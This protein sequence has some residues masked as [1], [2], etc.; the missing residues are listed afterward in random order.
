MTARDYIPLKV[1]LA[2]ALLQIPAEDGSIA[3]P[4]EHAKMLTP[5]QVISLFSRDHYPIRK[6]D[7]GPD[8]HWNIMFRFIGAHRIKTAK[9]DAPEIAKGA[10]LSKDHEDFRRRALARP[11]GQKRATSPR[12]P[13]GRKLRSRGFQRR[14]APAQRGKV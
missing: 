2:A 8:T 12:W 5:D 1:R 9:K 14:P 4:H 13:K 10:R 3:I 11:C 6:I 7:G